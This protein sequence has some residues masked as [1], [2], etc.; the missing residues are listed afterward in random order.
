MTAVAHGSP[1]KA[2]C[3]EVSDPR[4]DT[5]RAFQYWLRLAPQDRI[6]LWK[7]AR[8]G[9]PLAAPVITPSVSRDPAWAGPW[10]REAVSPGSRPLC[11][12]ISYF[13]LNMKY[14]NFRLR[15]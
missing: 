14:S 13:I 15:A 3:H 10:A 2:L 9:R 7:A 5:R 1:R 6:T 12:H 11:N 4:S 8:V